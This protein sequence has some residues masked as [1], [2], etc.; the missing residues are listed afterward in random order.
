MPRG[1]RETSCRAVFMAA[2]GLSRHAAPDLVIRRG[3]LHGD[4][5][6]RTLQTGGCGAPGR[7]TRVPAPFVLQPAA[8]ADKIL[9]HEFFKLRFGVFDEH[10]FHGDPVYPDHYLRRSKVTLT[11][12]AD[13]D[14]AGEW[15][16]DGG[17]G[18]VCG[19]AVDSCSFVPANNTALSCSLGLARLGA[20]LAGAWRY[21]DQVAAGAPTPHSALC[22]GETVPAV[23]LA[24]QDL[25]QLTGGG[26]SR[27]AAPEIV[28]VQ[29][30]LLNTLASQLCSSR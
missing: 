12:A 22:G 14:I 24:S 27:G 25:Q 23:I 2:A 18:A 4:A 21:C 28:T 16:E 19:G 8:G 1:W 7:V 6:P 3:L 13:T 11:A 26:R 10:G 20:G 29:V 17:S 9:A 30:T 5:R 15:R